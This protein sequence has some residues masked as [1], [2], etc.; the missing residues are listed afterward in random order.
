MKKIFRSFAW[1]TV[2]AVIT[3]L[4]SFVFKIYL[5]RALGA[6]I[7]SVYQL[8]MSVVATLACVRSSC[9]PV[10]LSRTVAENAALGKREKRDA[11]LFAAL[12][13]SASFALVACAVFIAF[14]P[15]A[16]LLFSD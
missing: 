8:A 2:T 16:Y 11:A 9:I 3:S 10:T 7:L 1:V 5:S 13:L 4:L 14:P 15:L 6:E 12:T